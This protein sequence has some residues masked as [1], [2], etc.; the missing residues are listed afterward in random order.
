MKVMLRRDLFLGGTRYRQDNLG[1]E[2]PDEV[3][4]K[5]VVL[6]KE[7]AP[8]EGEVMLPRDAV[9]W[10]QDVKPP[11]PPGGIRR[12]VT[13]GQS[14]PTTLSELSKHTGSDVQAKAESKK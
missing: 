9:L 6:F 7:G 12:R 10:T 5:K 4:N 2:I 14:A 8:A 11:P 1:T 13:G 3:D